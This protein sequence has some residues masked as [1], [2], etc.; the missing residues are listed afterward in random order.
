MSSLTTTCIQIQIRIPKWLTGSTTSQISSN[1]PAHSPKI[2]PTPPWLHSPPSKFM[3]RMALRPRI[4]QSA[5][6]SLTL[7][8]HFKS[9][10]TKWTSG[11]VHHQEC[12]QDSGGC[13]TMPNAGSKSTC[14]IPIK[15]PIGLSITTV[16]KESPRS[17]LNILLL[18]ARPTNTSLKPKASQPTSEQ[19]TLGTAPTQT[20][21]SATTKP[22]SNWPTMSSQLKRTGASLME[23]SVLGLPDLIY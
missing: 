19:H 2:E 14:K 13:R 11:L 16:L 21:P 5:S 22:K 20:Q 12:S 15:T 4:W 6:S 3:L 9:R 10:E 1:S 7:S 8:T 18:T 17:Q 23:S